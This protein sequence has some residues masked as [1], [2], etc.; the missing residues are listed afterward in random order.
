LFKERISF[1]DWNEFKNFISENGYA[2]KFD[3]K[4]GY[5]HVEILKEHQT[6]LGLSWESGKV[7]CYF[8]FTV[9]PF[10]L[11]PAPMIFTKLLRPLVSYWHTHSINICVFLDDG[12]GTERSLYKAVCNAKFVKKTLELSG[13]VVNVEKSIWFPQKR[14]TW[15]GVIVDF[16]NN[17]YYITDKRITTLISL[18]SCMLQKEFLTAREL[19]KLAG[20]IISMK[21]VMSE[22]TQLKTRALYEFIEK[23]VAWDAKIS[24]KNMSKAIKEIIFWEE[25]A[26]NLNFRKISEHHASSINV[27]SDASNSG[28][29]IC[30][31]LFEAQS[32]RNL[33]I[34]E[35]ELSSTWRE[36]MAILYGLNSFK[37]ILSGKVVNWFTDNYAASIIVKKG[38]SKVHLQKLA[39]DIFNVCFENSICIKSKW[40]PREQNKEADYISKFVD[41]DDW[42]ISDE[43]F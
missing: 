33:S 22:I 23:R 26:T 24:V 14:M 37:H 36:L 13:F 12:G 32:H 9:L 34:E 2:Y 11:S 1:D 30:I 6:F 43:F 31:P 21:F 27:Y 3:L 10:G 7:K 29:G 39:L 17:S 35:Q 19:S 5:H 41:T 4:K 18:T 42:Q 15:L 28:L 20:S 8:I 40:V 25:N 16:I 38:S